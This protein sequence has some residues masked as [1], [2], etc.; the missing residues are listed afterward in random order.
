MLKLYENIKKYR[1]ERGWNQSDLAK[2][3]GYSDKSM[4]SK[5]EKGLVDLSQSQIQKFADAFG[6]SASELFGP[7]PTQHPLKT[8]AVHSTIGSS[9]NHPYQTKVIKGRHA[10]EFRKEKVSLPE[11]LF[12]NSNENTEQEQESSDSRFTDEEQ[13]RLME[14]YGMTA[15]QIAFTEHL[16][17]LYLMADDRIKDAV[18]ALLCSQETE[19]KR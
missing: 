16:F 11:P 1:T 18:E 19:R 5:I 7:T 12:N 13:S 4:I 10:V 3:V 14:E 17:D 15:E 2:R 9:P 8:V 6:I